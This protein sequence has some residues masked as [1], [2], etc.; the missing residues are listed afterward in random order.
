MSMPNPL[1]KLL[2]TLALGGLAGIGLGCVISVQPLDCS[3]CGNT[4][5]NS[6]V[7]NGECRCDLGYE[8]ANDDPNDYECD[9]IPGKG[10]DASCGGE[11]H[12]H[13][14][15]Q[16]CVCDPGYNWCVPDDLNDLSCCIDDN[17]V[18][19]TDTDGPTTSGATETAGTADATETA[20]TTVDET[21]EPPGMCEQTDAP[22][23]GIE[24]DAADCTE[25]GLVF[26]SNNDVEGPAGSRYWEC[27]GGEWVEGVTV[28]DESCQFD[29]FDFAY[30]CVDDGSSVTFVCGVG[31]GTPCSGPA[32]N[33]CGGDGDQIEFCDDGK[34]GGD[35]C[36]RIC[37][38]DGDAEG[39][40][41]DFG[42]CTTD[43]GV[44]ECV[45]CDEGTEG[46]PV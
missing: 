38:E 35:S 32:C 42:Y 9:R 27:V 28:G 46:C 17:Q 6:Q 41:Y 3:E 45:C 34:L 14:E 40:T 36:F 8:F 15:G 44:A 37:S 26:C 39:I 13:L 1:P 21:G 19:G 2:W 20:D 4:G 29:G 7:V 5:C 16:V 43:G 33:G 23:N 30:G 22:W 25:D 18:P 24:P 11:D 12:V 10:G 31:P